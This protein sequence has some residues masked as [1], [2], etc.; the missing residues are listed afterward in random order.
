MLFFTLLLLNLVTKKVFDSGASVL[1]IGCLVV[2]SRHQESFGFRCDL[3]YSIECHVGNFRHQES[4]H[5][6][7]AVCYSIGCLVGNSHYQESFCF[8]CDLCYSIE[9]LVGNSRHQESF[10]FRCGLC[11]FTGCVVGSEEVRTVVTLMELYGYRGGGLTDLNLRTS[12][13]R[14]ELIQLQRLDG[15]DCR[16][17]E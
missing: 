13:Q 5:F 15:Q 11:Y 14:E 6:R 12:G 16:I 7:C 9:C 1:S 4:F 10:C 2:N 17:S 3:C 8:R